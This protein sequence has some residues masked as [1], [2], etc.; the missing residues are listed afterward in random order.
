MSLKIIT[1][2]LN[3]INEIFELKI[4]SETGVKND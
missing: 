1:K 4:S 3:K 2:L